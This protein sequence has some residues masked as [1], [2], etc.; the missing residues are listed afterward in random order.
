MHFILSIY[1]W[2]W[3]SSKKKI[4]SVFDKNKYELISRRFN[5]D[6]V[7]LGIGAVKNSFNK[8]EGIKVEYVDPADLV[9]SPTESPYFD[10]IYYVGE[11]KDVYG[12]YNNSSNYRSKSEDNNLIRVLYFEYKTYMNQVFKIK[13]TNT[14][15]KK[16]LEK[17]DD[18]NPP[19]NEEFERVDRVIEVIYQGVKVLGS[20]DRILKWEL[21]KNMMRPKADT[22]KAIMSYAI[23]AP[24]IY[25]GRIESLV[26]VLQVLQT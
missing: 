12:S 4:N 10:D 1:I 19:Q 17:S 11:V 23:V 16:A 8:A 5:Q 25:Q 6:L 22:T 9:Y 26:A 2:Y 13:N 15:G 14:G 18:F 21:K 20:G 7:T 24:R 3:N